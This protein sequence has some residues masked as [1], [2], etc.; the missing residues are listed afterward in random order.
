M[1]MMLAIKWGERCSVVM[2]P[3]SF[4]VEIPAASG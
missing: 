1:L 4:S 2:V 3:S